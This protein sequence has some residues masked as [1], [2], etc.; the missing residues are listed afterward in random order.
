MPVLMFIL[1]IPAFLN[2][3]EDH[4]DIQDHGE[5]DR[6]L[7]IIDEQTGAEESTFLEIEREYN[8]SI[9]KFRTSLQSRRQPDEELE[10]TDPQ[11]P[12]LSP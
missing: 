10:E 9:K 11:C 4:P 1:C 5:T 6:L 12:S 2:P 3:W 8:D 7:R